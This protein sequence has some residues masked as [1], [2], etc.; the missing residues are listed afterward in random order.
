MSANR[1]GVLLL[2]AITVFLA[3]AKAEPPKQ[4]PSAAPL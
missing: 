2:L 4:P 1:T 3:R